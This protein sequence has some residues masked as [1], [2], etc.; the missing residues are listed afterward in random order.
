MIRCEELAQGWF[1]VWEAEPVSEVECFAGQHA[2]VVQHG[3]GDVA[4]GQA[5]HGARKTEPD[6]T[7]QGPS[8]RVGVVA[9]AGRVGCGCVERPLDALVAEGEME[10]L[11][12]VI[13]VDPGQPLAA[14]QDDGAEPAPELGCHLHG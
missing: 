11:H 8:H 6:G 2:P 14:G 4:E 5:H 10:Q 13:D 1:K 9:V 12:L 7:V 3:V